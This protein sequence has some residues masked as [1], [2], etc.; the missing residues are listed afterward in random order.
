MTSKRRS[1]PPRPTGATTPNSAMCART[2][3]ASMVSCRCSISLTLCSMIALCC[4]CD[5]AV[6]NRMAGRVTASAIASASARPFLCRFTYV[7]SRQ[8]HQSRSLEAPSRQPMNGSSFSRSNVW[9]RA[10]SSR[11]SHFVGGRLPAHACARSFC[12]RHRA[13]ARQGAHVGLDLPCIAHIIELP[14]RKA[15]R[16]CRLFGE[17]RLECALRLIGSAEPH[18]RDGFVR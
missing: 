7:E 2:A 16:E 8:Q 3:L 15:D 4:S 5:F 12:S 10:A 1:R 6:T 13:R 9:P 17:R 11:S 14:P 18:Q